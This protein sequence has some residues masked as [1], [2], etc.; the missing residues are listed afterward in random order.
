M[1]NNTI[2][3]RE[4]QLPADGWYQIMPF[5]EFPVTMD[6]VGPD[7]KPFVRRLV[8]V[9]DTASASQMLN[10]FAAESATPEF[11]GMLVDFDHFS[12]DTDK[13]SR[14]AGWAMALENRADG[15]YAQI[16]WS[17][18]GEGAVKG[19]D[20]RFISPVFDFA[21]AEQLGG[22][23]VRPVRMLNMA[24]TNDANMKGRMRPLTN[25][26]GGTAEAPQGKDPN[27]ALKESLCQVLGLPPE[28]A[29]DAV[30]AKV[31]E[32]AN[33]AKETPALKNRVADLEHKELETAVEKDLEDHKAVIANRD[34]VKAQLLANRE[35]TLKVLKSLRPAAPE[36]TL[37]NRAGNTLPDG[38]AAVTEDA[39][40]DQARAATILNRTHEIRK[41]TKV[42]F[43]RAFEMAEAEQKQ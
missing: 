41:T 12:H 18:S 24:V 3:N 29:D 8:Q 10:R 28:T 27:M 31:Q 42:S 1:N 14:A 25:R 35:G 36:Q 39:P 33:C 6:D 2:L 26:G 9:C 22:G 7:G 34:D 40:A 13:S 17:A 19:G 32:L 21:T 30:M 23:R 4:F 5:G 15:L 11:A 38:A 37:P 20:F 16:R 43:S